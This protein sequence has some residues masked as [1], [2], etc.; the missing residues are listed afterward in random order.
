MV[1]FDFPAISV[2]PV[3]LLYCMD[4]V[5]VP[6]SHNNSYWLLE[7]IIP[8]LTL[9]MEISWVTVEIHNLLKLQI[10]ISALKHLVF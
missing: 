3:Y 6:D 5:G 1:E 10:P 9:S 7:Q 4:P 2:T 8:M